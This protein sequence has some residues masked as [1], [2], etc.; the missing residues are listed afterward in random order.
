MDLASTEKSFV[1]MVAAAT[2][3][4]FWAIWVAV[5]WEP[6]IEARLRALR[7]RRM[8]TRS[9]FSRSAI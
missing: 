2:F 1:V 3:V 9:R 7:T 4:A 6:P 5:T 8:K